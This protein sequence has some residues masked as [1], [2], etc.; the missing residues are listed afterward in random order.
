MIHELKLKTKLWRSAYRIKEFESHLT[1]FQSTKPA[2]CYGCFVAHQPLLCC[3]LDPGL[4]LKVCQTALLSLNA[5][6]SLLELY[7]PLSDL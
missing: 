4:Q 7:T 2:S 3:G 5:G 6:F 1:W